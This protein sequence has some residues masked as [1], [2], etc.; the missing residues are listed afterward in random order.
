MAATKQRRR[1]KEPRRLRS[2][3]FVPNRGLEIEYARQLRGLVKP[4]VVEVKAE[5]MKLYRRYAP[6]LAMDDMSDDLAAILDD[7]YSRFPGE[8]EMQ[9]RALATAMVAKQKDY[10]DRTFKDRMKDLLPLALLLP[11][12]VA[13]M[14]VANAEK[15]IADFPTLPPKSLAGIGNEMLQSI[16][17]TA[18]MTPEM[19]EVLQSAVIENVSL[20]RTIP[21]KFLDRVAGAMTRAIQA[22]ANVKALEEILNK[23]GD[24]SMNHATRI[25]LDQ[26]FKTFTAINL[27]KFQAAGITK[28]EWVHTGLSKKPREFHITDAPDGLNH[29]VFDLDDPPIIDQRTGERGYPGQLPFCRCVMCAVVDADAMI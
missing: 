26:V 3:P 13:T 14:G 22:G 4:M 20:V 21:A 15:T 8:F 12:G 18:A 7:Y 10:A 2:S 23:Y 17:N 9:G 16:S 5:M 28:F 24:I 19:R 11:L 27:R 6:G 1:R 29:G 25:A